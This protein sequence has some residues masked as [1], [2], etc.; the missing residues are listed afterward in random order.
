MEDLQHLIIMIEFLTKI[1][2]PNNL[3]LVKPIK[4]V[5]SSQLLFRINILMLPKLSCQKNN[6]ILKIIIIRRKERPVKV[7]EIPD[8]FQR[9]ENWW[10]NSAI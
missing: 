7:M 5:S 6:K 4:Q 1:K 8:N 3:G 10:K 9:T 2:T